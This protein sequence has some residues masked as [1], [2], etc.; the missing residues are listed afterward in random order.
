MGRRLYADSKPPTHSSWQILTAL[1]WI[2]TQLPPKNYLEWKTSNIDTP[3]QYSSIGIY[4]AFGWHG[5]TVCEVDIYGY[6]K[7]IAYHI[8]HEKC[9]LFGGLLSLFMFR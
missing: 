5:F 2:N 4:K 3:P 6:C 8:N 1:K 9:N 7:F